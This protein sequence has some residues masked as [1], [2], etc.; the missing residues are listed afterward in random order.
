MAY[1]DDWTEAIEILT[2]SDLSPMIT[3][4]FSL[5]K[6]HDALA[7]AQSTEEGAKVMI[8]ADASATGD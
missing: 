8:I 2:R 1:P 7:V 3:H 6:F 5:E 4:Q